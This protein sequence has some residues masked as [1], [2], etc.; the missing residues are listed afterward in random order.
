MPYRNL[1]NSLSVIAI[2]AVV[3]YGAVKY[4]QKENS[5]NRYLA[6]MTMGKMAHEQ[7][8]KTVFDIKV[9]NVEVGLTES[10][11]ST[12]QVTIEA[13]SEISDGL[14]Y[15]WHLP[16]DITVSAGS[17][18]G[19]LPKFSVNDTQ[20]LELKIKGYSKAKKSFISFSVEGRLGEAKLKREVLLS[21][22]PEDS[23]EYIVQNYEKSK[24]S[25]S[26]ISNKLRK[27]EYKPL[28]DIKNV[29]H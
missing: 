11:V 17:Q 26:K 15:S 4:I 14:I 18:Q 10:D 2:S 8:S 24:Q 20:T 27:A 1:L 28:I 12:V 9:K 7:Y 21:S 25:E 5:P 3:G 23:F 16:D 6:S 22:R 13:F 19:L 29:V